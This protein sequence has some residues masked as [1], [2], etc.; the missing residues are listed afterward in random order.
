[1]IEVKEKNIAM[2]YKEVAERYSS[3]PSFLTR[4]GN[5]YVGPTYSELYEQGLQ[6]AEGLIDLGVQAG[7][8]VGI[9]A[10]NRLE[11]ILTDYGIQICGAADVPRGTDVTEK[12]I[13]YILSHAE[14]KVV[15]VEHE[16]ILKKLEQ[17]QA[18]LPNL[19]HI[20][21][22]DKESKSPNSS[23]LK[24]YDIIEKGRE[25][26]KN[27]SRKA[28]ERMEKIQPG[29]TCTLIYTSGTTGDPKGV[30]L[31]HKN[32][33][34]PA[35][36]IPIK[37]RDTDRFLSILPIWHI[38]ER[39]FAVMAAS[40]GSSTYYTN[41]RNLRE[42]FA[43]ARPTFMASAPRLWENIYLGIKKKID[44]GPAVP[45][46]LFTAACFCS[47]QV[48]SSIL[49]LKGKENDLVNRNILVSALIRAPLRVLRI[50]IFFLPFLLLNAV[51]LRK[52]RAA[53][54]GCLRGS[55]SGGGALPPHVDR[56][57]NNIGI[58]VLEGYGMTETTAVLAART[59]QNLII[60]S[61]GF[62]WPETQIRL[63]DISSGK[64]VYPPKRGVK[65][66][67]HAKGD[68]IMNGYYK[69]PEATEKV[70]KDGWMNTGDLG[71]ITF[72]NVLKIVGRSKET[73]VLLGGENVEPVPI[74]NKLLISPIIE[75]CMVV[76]QDKKYLSCLIVP[77]VEHL[78][79]YGQD[80]AS[81][82]QNAEAL[83]KMQTEVKSLISTENGFKSFEKVI[84]CRILSKPFE[85]GDE[86][87]NLFKLKRFI[88]TEKYNDLIAQMYSDS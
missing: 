15:F 36:T 79:D 50:I 76:G 51:V 25:L 10:D 80:Y 31:S 30:L 29:D 44:S 8:H 81:I 38:F 4:K 88:T 82:A 54:G 27:G 66:E 28:E 64:V 17:V 72:K 40:T 6:L 39:A 32:V 87:T 62:P 86:L 71:I 56:F 55:I 49:F 24:L 23:V 22:M 67:I 21:M 65:G 84:D 19:T 2:L 18:T 35:R 47:N 58:S 83:K 33:V 5:E 3:N 12:E 46:A 20:I 45:R 1:M 77:S 16:K 85:V 63:V 41:I 14:V 68:Q 7:E 73:I 70:L 69:N 34:A 60:G 37:I 11:W 61:V 13:T 26:R 78:P 53:T 9:L 75:H 59:F 52:I 74:E 57:F 48:K 42:D 43:I